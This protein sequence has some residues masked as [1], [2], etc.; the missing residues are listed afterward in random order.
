MKTNGAPPLS[1]LT[2]CVSPRASAI[3]P[4]RGPL[5]PPHA[6]RQPLRTP[7]QANANIKASHKYGS[8]WTTWPLNDAPV[9][10][11]HSKDFGPD[12]S[13][14]IYMA[15]NPLIYLLAL[16]GG[17]CFDRAAVASP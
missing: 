5:S 10:Y 2:R 11:W 16:C 6:V 14:C 9:Y 8:R 4:S 17:T 1:L 15:G 3:H 13:A 7:R 12:R